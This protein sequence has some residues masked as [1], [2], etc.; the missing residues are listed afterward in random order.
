ML[1]AK[2]SPWA[3][4]NIFLW[5]I[6]SLINNYVY[7]YYNIFLSFRK[8]GQAPS[9]GHCHDVRLAGQVPVLGRDRQGLPFDR[10][11][12]NIRN[13]L[14]NWP[15]LSPAR[16][17]RQRGNNRLGWR[18]FGPRP[19][20]GVQSVLEVMHKICFHYLLT[21]YLIIYLLTYFLLIIYLF[22]ICLIFTLHN[23]SPICPKSRNCLWLKMGINDVIS[24]IT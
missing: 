3:V 7:I 5:W 20:L 23:M 12:K 4:Q 22:I 16:S 24:K 2:V 21:Y 10:S 19:V 9:K 14:Q 18:S 17:T 13:S 6:H 11:I 15:Q 8:A 1:H